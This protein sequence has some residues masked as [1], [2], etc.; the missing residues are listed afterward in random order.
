[1]QAVMYKTSS[2]YPIANAEVTTGVVV[3]IHIIADGSPP[4][5]KAIV[6]RHS[7]I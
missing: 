6:T 5:H 4:A 1:M 3:K 2:D 7:I